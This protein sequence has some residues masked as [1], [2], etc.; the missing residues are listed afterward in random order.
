MP[1]LS[2][3]DSPNFM[4]REKKQPDRHLKEFTM[5]QTEHT[6]AN[7][8]P[9]GRHDGR[10]LELD[11]DR[12]LAGRL[13]I[14]GSSGAGK[15]ATLRRIVEEAFEYITTVIVDPEGEFANLAEHIGAARIQGSSLTCE[16]MT[17]AALRARKHRIALHVD[18]SDLD[19]EERIVKAA[20]FFAGLMSAP[21]ETWPNTMLV[22][23]DEGHLL[24]P[25][26]AGSA[27]D[28]ETR[29][30]GVAALTDLCSRGRKR[31]LATI[32]ATQRLAKLSASVTSELLNFL[33]GLNV[34]DRD[35]QRAAD[36]LG[37]GAREAE[38]LRSLAPGEF[39]ALGP[40]L[41]AT[42]T[43]AKIDPTITRH[44]G[45][46]P[47]L[48]GC[49]D[50]SAEEAR[51]LLDLE[52]MEAIAAE[53]KAKSIALRGT[54][55]LDSFLLDPTAGLAVTTLQALARISPNATTCAEICEHTGQEAA[56]VHAANMRDVALDV[57]LD[58]RVT[59]P[60]EG[61]G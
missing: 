50:H 32:V 22:C 49:A 29:R 46:T 9:I 61:L 28:A 40:A 59:D 19:P 60:S 57:A 5:N 18:L 10:P 24:A 55:A 33:V 3:S 14:Q 35:V 23:I 17:S 38:R 36:F 30:M 13:L 6:L 54:R 47:E 4:R 11:L 45:A 51:R 16:G 2:E 21:A 41:V 15:S 8:V 42:A 1:P 56:C 52:C 37:F 20:A 44:V 53:P 39:Y 25:H 12:L 31:G 27:R 48:V 58:Q 43:L 34:F 26:V 7:R